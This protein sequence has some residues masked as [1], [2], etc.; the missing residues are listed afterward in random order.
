MNSA[1]LA[2]KML[3]CMRWD[4]ALGANKIHTK[5]LT[6]TSLA[7]KSKH[8]RKKLKFEKKGAHVALFLL[9][10]LFAV[11][12]HSIRYILFTTFAFTTFVPLLYSFKT[13]MWRLRQDHYIVVFI[14][15]F[16]Y[17]KTNERFRF[18][19]TTRNWM[20]NRLREDAN[21]LAG[22]LCLSRRLSVSCLFLSTFSFCFTNT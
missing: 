11:I 13:T 10:I 2:C 17:V 19:A 5:T 18:K 12:G 15:T 14:F 22:R 20:H 9:G 3:G 16:V 7:T 4:A 1:C 8:I 6:H 21:Q